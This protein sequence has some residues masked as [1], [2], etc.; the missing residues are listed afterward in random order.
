L[1]LLGTPAALSAL[2]AAL[3]SAQGEMLAAV[4]ACFVRDDPA[5]ARGAYARLLRG[6][7]DGARRTAASALRDVPGEETDGLLLAALDDAD[8]GVRVLAFDSL[9][10]R[11]GLGAY[12][13]RGGLLNRMALRLH[14][15]LA[16]LRAPAIVL[17]RDLLAGLRSGSSPEELGLAAP[18]PGPAP[19]LARLVLSFR[20]DPGQPPYGDD[21]DLD[22]LDGLDAGARSWAELAFVA[23]LEDGDFRAPRALAHMR[24]T[25]AREPLEE[26]RRTATGRF[27]AEVQRALERL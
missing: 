24:S 27:A 1:R 25:L 10:G 4:A 19:L 22:A 17:L 11:Y 9:R 14:S 3:E 7:V 21:F 12:E 23:L 15:P 18:A 8:K 13:T 6:G 2:R 26:A 16:S 5:A 20:S